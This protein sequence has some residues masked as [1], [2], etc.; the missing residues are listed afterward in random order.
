MLLSFIMVYCDACTLPAP[1]ALNSF[2]GAEAFVVE[3][4][5]PYAAKRCRSLVVVY[6]CFEGWCGSAPTVAG[7][8]DQ[9]QQHTG[10]QHLTCSFPG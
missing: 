4:L 9:P 5:P 6:A 8:A 2:E 7:P 3:P 1:V 10:R